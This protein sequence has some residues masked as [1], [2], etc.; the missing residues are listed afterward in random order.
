MQYMIMSMILISVLL[1]ISI[2]KWRNLA[3]YLFYFEVFQNLFVWSMPQGSNSSQVALSR[4]ELSFAFSHICLFLFLYTDKASQIIYNSCM[5][6][7][8]TFIVMI[9]F[10]NQEITFKLAS[11]KLFMVIGVFVLNSMIASVII[12]I[13]SLHDRLKVFNEQNI[14]LLDGMHEG[15]LIL[16]K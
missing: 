1:D 7:I 13:A 16:A 6:L 11:I 15:L 9:V 4:T 10:F 12:Y 14:K 8:L 3:N 5:Q 2:L